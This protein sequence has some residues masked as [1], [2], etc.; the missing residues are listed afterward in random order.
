MASPFLSPGSSLLPPAP[1][2]GPAPGLHSAGQA[3]GYFPVFGTSGSP[4]TP[5]GKD[6]KDPHNTSK[7]ESSS[8][9]VS[10][11]IDD[12]DKTGI[13]VGFLF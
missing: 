9:V 4:F 2:P 3:S 12:D 6:A 10:S 5:V 13:K 1:A 11:T 7:P 8:N